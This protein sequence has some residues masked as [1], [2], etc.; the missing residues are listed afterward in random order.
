MS[1]CRALEKTIRAAYLGPAGTFS[2]Q[3]D[4]RATSAQS[5][6]GLPCPS[7]DEVFRAAEAG[8]ADFGVVPVENSAEGA[9][10]RTLDLLL[11]TPL[12]IGGELA[13][14]I[15]HNLLTRDR[16]ARRRDAR[17]R[18][19]AGAGAVPGLAHRPTR[20]IS[21]ARRCR[22]TP[23][24]RAWRSKIRRIAAIASDRA[25]THYGLGNV[26]LAR[27]RTIRTT[28]PAS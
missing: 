14:P 15:H 1:A 5:I 9:V 20:R 28:A 22:A 11:Q 26:V 24:R 2:E 12:T 27:S 4:V 3:A 19:S 16:H 13:L 21:S 18:A 6:E 23:K 8:A 7:I 25:A 17:L 10:S